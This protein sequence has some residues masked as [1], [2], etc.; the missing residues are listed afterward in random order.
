MSDLERFR[1]ETRAWLL[2]NAPKSMFTRPA[3]RTT[4]A[5]A[6]GR[7][8]IRGRPPA[9]SRSWRSAAGPAPTWPKEYGG[10]G[11]SKEEAKSYSRRCVA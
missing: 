5:G 4:F 8:S 7:P 3:P 10:G 6:A 1:A 2:A 11:L 9:G